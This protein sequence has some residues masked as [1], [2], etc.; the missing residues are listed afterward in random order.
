MRQPNATDPTGNCHR[1]SPAAVCSDHEQYATRE[2]PTATAL[3]AGVGRGRDGVRGDAWR[4]TGT[5]NASNV[6][7][8]D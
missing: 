3:L 2:R 4:T 5:G 8:H 7:T 1:C 6:P